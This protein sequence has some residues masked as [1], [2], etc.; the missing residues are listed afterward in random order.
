MRVIFSKVPDAMDRAPA[1]RVRP[2]SSRT[3]A[4]TSPRNGPASKR[5]HV[6]NSTPERKTKS[7][8][9]GECIVPD[10]EDELDVDEDTVAA[11]DSRQQ[12]QP[13]KRF[14]AGDIVRAPRLLVGGSYGPEETLR[15]V[16]LEASGWRAERVDFAGAKI[17]PRQGNSPGFVL[18]QPLRKPAT[19]TQWFGFSRYGMDAEA[20]AEKSKKELDA[21]DS[22]A[23]LSQP[24]SEER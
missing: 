18:E 14:T 15:L 5:S 22:Q 8:V 23:S 12:E 21:E 7:R 11:E 19:Y 16:A 1:G 24:K 10:S 6:P 3:M 13:I 17:R 4:C 9:D 20:E 2:S